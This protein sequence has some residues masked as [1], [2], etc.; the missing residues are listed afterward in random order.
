MGAIG[1]YID[2]GVL[3]IGIIE[4]TYGI[5]TWL[6]YKDILGSIPLLIVGSLFILLGFI[7][8][9]GDQLRAVVKMQLRNTI[10]ILTLYS[11]GITD[12]K[13]RA[14]LERMIRELSK[15]LESL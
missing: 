11:Q 1:E 12:E 10:L 7:M 2:I 3:I 13:N 4:T 15:A 14:K 5:V 8:A 9:V 6:T